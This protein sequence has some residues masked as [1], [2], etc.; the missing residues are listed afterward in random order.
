MTHGCD[1]GQLLDNSSIKCRTSDFYKLL[2]YTV[3]FRGTKSLYSV[4]LVLKKMCLQM[5]AQ[6]RYDPG[7][8]VGWRSLQGLRRGVPVDGCAV[9]CAGPGDGTLENLIFNQ[10]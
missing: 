5:R 7:F 8:V 6:S 3:V 10:G 4:R 1:T 2:M 9:T